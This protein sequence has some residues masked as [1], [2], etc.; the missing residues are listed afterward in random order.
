MISI[1]LIENNFSYIIYIHIFIRILNLLY[2][3]FDIKFI[4][5]L[6]K[7]IKFIYFI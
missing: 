6:K 1:N 2:Y 3:L 4:F 7:S 5:I